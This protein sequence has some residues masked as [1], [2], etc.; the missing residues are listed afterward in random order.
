MGLQSFS[1][2]SCSDG[3]SRTYRGT[4]GSGPRKASASIATKSPSASMAV[5]TRSQVVENTEL[6]SRF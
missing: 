6:D 4:A 5:T 3:L 1:P 2:S